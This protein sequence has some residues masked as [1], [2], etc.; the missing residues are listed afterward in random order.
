MNPAFNRL[1]SPALGRLLREPPLGLIA[2]LFVIG[3]LSWLAFAGRVTSG[4]NREI[5]PDCRQYIALTSHLVEKGIFSLD[6]QSPSAR[7]EPGY[8]A[9]VAPFMKAGFVE[10]HVLNFENLWPVIASQIVLYGLAAWGLA[11]RTAGQ[12]GPAAGLMCL[13]FTQGWWGLCVHQHRFLSECV[14]MVCLAGAWLLLGDAQ[15]T[16]SSWMTLLGGAVL[17]GYACLTKS[18]FVLTVPL[19]ALLMWWRGGVSMLRSAVFAAVVLALPLAWTAR[20]QQQF[21]LPIM[22]SIDGVSSLYRGNVL[23]FTQI[24]SPEEPDMPQEAKTA[25]AGMT[26]DAQRYV[27]FKTHALE[28]MRTEPGRYALQCANRAVYML[29]EF[30]LASLPL[31]RLV[32]LIKNDHFMVM[33]ILALYLPALLSGSR[34]DFFVEAALALFVVCL[35]LYSLVY[36]ETRYLVPCMFLMAP[37]YAAAIMDL[38]VGPILRRFLPSL[39]RSAGILDTGLGKGTTEL[40][41]SS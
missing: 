37:L 33:L 6:G 28:I 11:R 29:T 15:R 1:L 21:G 35:G 39:A 7:R 17:F 22:G 2:L 8:V 5:T 4:W 40:S 18:I 31:W 9:F 24:P 27:W 3:H 20:N 23:P 14:A 10:P 32:L 19:L 26:S 25:L 30:D 36:G 34:R 13:F 41:A 12:F 38:V 16:R